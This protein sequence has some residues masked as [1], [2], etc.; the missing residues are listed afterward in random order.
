MT[1]YYCS[2]CICCFHYW[3]RMLWPRNPRQR[4]CRGLPSAKTPRRIFRRRRGLCR[5]PF[6]GHSAK[7]RTR[8][9]PAPLAVSLPRAALG[10]EMVFFLI[11]LPRA[12]PRQIN[13]FIFFK[14]LCRGPPPWPSVK[15]FS[16]F[17]LNKS[18][19]RAIARALGKGFFFK[20]NCL[21]RAGPRQRNSFF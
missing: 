20:K 7:K 3:R 21:L 18:L 10:K 14:N 15:K 17:F 1:T 19:P 2:M 8:H 9:A 11:C 13:F 6:I 16:E 12:D 4:L 5:G